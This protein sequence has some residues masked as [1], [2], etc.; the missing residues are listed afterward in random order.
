MASPRSDAGAGGLA[1]Q[2]ERLGRRA[3][4]AERY[5]ARLHADLARAA[6]DVGAL[7]E[8]L[9]AA[10]AAL[11]V[12][13]RGG[14][15]AG[16]AA[17]RAHDELRRERQRAAVLADDR[18]AALD[19][20]QRALAHS[21]ALADAL[22]GREQELAGTHDAVRELRGALADAD[23]A[24]AG[25]A[26][27]LEGAVGRAGALEGALG[28]ERARAAAAQQ[29]AHQAR[30]LAGAVQAGAA[31]ELAAAADHIAGLDRE[32]GD[33]RRALRDALAPPSRVAACEAA[34]AATR[35]H[36]EQLAAERD[37][38]A[39]RLRA[40]DDELRG[41]A[42]A[43]QRARADAALAV[44]ARVH[45]AERARSQQLQRTHDDM[46]QRCAA[47]AAQLQAALRARDDAAAELA[48]YE[49]G[50][51]LAAV[52]A[53]ARQLAA[54]LAA[55]DADVARLTAH[56]GAQWE[57]YD[58]LLEALRRLAPPGVDD[59][60]ALFPLPQ[61]H[62]SVRSTWEALRA[63]N[64]ELARQNETLESQR[65]QLLQRLRAR[66]AL[67][68]GAAGGKLAEEVDMEE[69]ED[70]AQCSAPLQ[71]GPPAGQIPP[72]PPALS[73][74]PPPQPVHSPGP[75]A[76]L[77]EAAEA[78]RARAAAWERLAADND[79]LHAR[80]LELSLRVRA[81]PSAASLASDGHPPSHTTGSS[82]DDDSGPPDSS[83][84]SPSSLQQ[85]Q[86][87][88]DDESELADA[89]ELLAHA[90]SQR[91]AIHPDAAA[92][93]LSL[94]RRL[95]ASA[96]ASVQQAAA[97]AAAASAASEGGTSSDSVS[98]D[99]C[100]GDGDRSRS[101]CGS[102]R[103]SS[104]GSESSRSLISVCS[105]LVAGRASF[106]PEAA[107]APPSD[108]AAA[109]AT[110]AA[111]PR[112]T[113]MAGDIAALQ[114]QLRLHA[115]TNDALQQQLRALL[116]A[117]E[118]PSILP[119]WPAEQAAAAPPPLDE[120]SAA[121]PPPAAAAGGAPS[122]AAEHALA[123]AQASRD[124]ACADA[125]AARR[126]LR[127][128]L[129]QQGD[130]LLLLGQYEQAGSAAPGVPPSAPLSTRVQQLHTVLA[131]A[132]ELAQRQRDEVTRIVA[133]HGL[134]PA[135]FADFFLLAPA[136]ADSV[137]AAADAPD[138][139]AAVAATASAAAAA[140][141]AAAASSTA[142]ASL[143]A[144]VSALRTALRTQC[145]LAC[146]RRRGLAVR[147]AQ[148]SGLLENLQREAG[149][150]ASAYLPSEAA[151]EEG[152]VADSELDEADEGAASL[153][154]S[155]DACDEATTDSAHCI[156]TAPSSQ[157]AAHATAV[158]VERVRDAYHEEL[159]R[160]QGAA[161]ASIGALREQLRARD[162]AEAQLRA[163][164]GDIATAHEQQL[165][166]LR[167][168][169]D[170][171]VVAGEASAREA[172][173]QATA[174]LAAGAAGGSHASAALAASDVAQLQRVVCELEAAAVAGEHR[175]SELEAAVGA[176]KDSEAAAHE[177][178]A[179]TD[180]ELGELRVQMLVVRGQ[181]QER[182]LACA[183][184]E[185]ADAAARQAHAAEL[186]ARDRKLATLTAALRVLRSELAAA[187]SEHVAALGALDTETQRLQRLQQ[188]Q[189]QP[190]E[191][192]PQAPP[193]PAPLRGGANRAQAASAAAAGAAA[194][195]V[196]SE[197]LQLAAEVVRLTGALAAQ[198]AATEHASAAAARLR[199]QLG[200]LQRQLKLCQS[201]P[202]P[203]LPDSAPAPPPPPPLP[204]LPARPAA[205]A[206]AAAAA[207]E[208]E[209]SAAAEAQRALRKR[210]DAL[211]ASKARLQ[212][213][214]EASLARETASAARCERLRGERDALMRRL[215]LAQRR[216][217][218]LQGSLSAATAAGEAAAALGAAQPSLSSAAAAAGGAAAPPCAPMAPPEAA[219]QARLELR[220]A[221]S[222]LRVLRSQLGELEAAPAAAAALRR[223]LQK[224]H[225]E[226]ATL[227]G[228]LASVEAAAQAASESDPQPS[229]G[230][231]PPRP[232]HARR[233]RSRSKTVPG[234]AAAASAAGIHAAADADAAP[235]K[236]AE[237]HEYHPE[238]V[239]AALRLRCA[240]LEARLP[241][242][243]RTPAAASANRADLEGA[244]SDDSEE[245]AEPPVAVRPTL[246]LVSA[247]GP[248]S[249]SSALGG[250]GEECASEPELLHR[251]EAR[252]L[253]E[254]VRSQAAE[255]RRLRAELREFDGAFFESLEALK[256]EYAQAADKCRAFDA[257]VRRYPPTQG[258]PEE[259]L[260]SS[261]R[262]AAS[263]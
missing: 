111:D 175:V 135:A 239:V 95:H 103:G 190:A 25:L 48:R 106:A 57:R 178:A 52:A 206:D 216:C 223:A 146:A 184:W 226:L 120:V 158:A 64:A 61:L 27:E 119:R 18:S 254:Q 45:D 222:E 224:A 157:Q 152:G 125:S 101:P 83:V 68:H 198:Q 89:M 17:A 166:A 149:V 23:A 242:A 114:S 37:D 197:R 145:A 33:A 188:Q 43:L 180:M 153:A 50:H 79:A 252:R 214:L 123:R 67:T 167:A 260:E 207:E 255:L 183:R 202:P 97:A 235:A 238:A 75:S 3:A 2:A 193:T 113:A 231:S 65:W 56:A 110:A 20:L 139:V 6:Q 209:S 53:E 21:D 230:S 93:L 194:A 257:Y 102:S 176:A 140:A 60:F 169:R 69:G 55:R 108:C 100:G 112:L 256:W 127:A 35:S 251:E 22:R 109:A 5:N 126:E 80:V 263:R 253:R 96:S 31:R 8:Q 142:A 85:Q 136:Q 34:L 121:P 76:E 151:L 189:Q 185:A 143:R 170:A 144:R 195:V 220:A 211:A 14:S 82:L 213:Q 9:A 138:A 159:L 150:D 91:R 70:G 179:S 78:Q 186:A 90:S 46:Q 118:A 116:A 124:E 15:A 132:R 174:A 71:R 38:L 199:L 191:E 115:A 210:S 47:Q 26:R 236:C 203:A 16:D 192:E 221:K 63:A 36:A 44:D 172:V 32:L 62:A 72:P 201:Q 196:A 219:E 13:Q 24:R 164:A 233:A 30:A 129:V 87:Q 237:S 73:G 122:V 243:S 225:G 11:A 42:G 39:R 162:A 51:G 99:G 74:A 161:H 245:G 218:A 12:A 107:T 117:G 155:T 104:R 173:Q 244:P 240:Q 259:L 204:R 249:P 182:E 156:A 81:A 86:Q 133:R 181:L 92:P 229:G 262:H 168:Q 28:A 148:L 137:A 7:Q 77:D 49:A 88:E 163:E 154:E 177:R 160:V 247:S 165:S 227:R 94:L 4:D 241:P 84:W 130:L 215:E 29:A 217:E 58:L 40:A 205:A 234:D 208:D 250:A 1:A 232:T 134:Q 187:E 19:E 128:L 41:C 66:A 246:V 171:A 248:A 59:V 131:A 105:S 98:G 10:E 212:A 228:R 200:T 54:A 141:A 147:T 261:V 258:L